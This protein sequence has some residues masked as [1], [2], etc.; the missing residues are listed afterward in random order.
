M[1]SARPELTTPTTLVILVVFVM[2][3]WIGGVFL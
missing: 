3:I 2:G 1:Q